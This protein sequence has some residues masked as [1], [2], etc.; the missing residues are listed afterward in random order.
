L[1]HRAAGWLLAAVLACGLGL[2]APQVEAQ[3]IG[4]KIKGI[5]EPTP[6]PKKRKSSSS[7]KKK[8]ASTPHAFAETDTSP[9]ATPKASARQSRQPRRK[10]CFADSGARSFCT[11]TPKSSPSP[12]T[13]KGRQKEGVTEPFAERHTVS[14]AEATPTPAPSETP[15]SS[16][17]PGTAHGSPAPDGK[18]RALRRREHRA[19]RAERT[20]T[21]I[22]RGEEARRVVTDLAVGI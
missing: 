9:S 4:D 18:K 2:T 6:A 5:F 10:H 20:S 3:S 17:S 14:F 8:T 11:P 1:T 22:R 16:P 7:T 15:E 13:K 19:E 12:S 21:A